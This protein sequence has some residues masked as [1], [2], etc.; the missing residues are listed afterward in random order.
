MTIGELA[1]RSGLQASALRY[2]EQIGLIPAPLRRGG[3]RDYASDALYRL[4]VV[5]CARACGFTLS[6]IRWLVQGFETPD[7]PR[8]RTLAESKIKEMK[9]R[10]ER[11]HEMMRVLQRI[12]RCACGTIEECGQR[13][14]GSTRPRHRRK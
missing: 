13:L 3:R 8:W 4:E 10:I 11:A 2:Y 1:T 5:Q 7:S 14:S 12:K 9:Q 6:E